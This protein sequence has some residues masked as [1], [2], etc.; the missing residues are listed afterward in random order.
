MKPELNISND[1]NAVAEP[2]NTLPRSPFEN[3]IH[4]D[5]FIHPRDLINFMNKKL[6]ILILDIRPEDHFQA[7]RITPSVG[8]CINIPENI[9]RRG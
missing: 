1:I 8:D 4:K 6:N 3:P 9:I 7:C 5:L 2:T